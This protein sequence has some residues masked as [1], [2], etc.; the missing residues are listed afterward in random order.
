MDTGEPGGVGGGVCSIC[1]HSMLTYTF[2]SGGYTFE[3]LIFSSFQRDMLIQE[4]IFKELKICG[5]PMYLNISSYFFI[6][7]S[8]L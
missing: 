5:N 6:T 1:Q 4:S 7:F 8:F 2:Q 3:Q